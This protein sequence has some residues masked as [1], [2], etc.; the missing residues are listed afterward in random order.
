[1]ENVHDLKINHI[2]SEHRKVGVANAFRNLIFLLESQT[3]I[4][5]SSG[6]TLT[7]LLVKRVLHDQFVKK[8]TKLVV[9]IAM[10]KYINKHAGKYVTNLM[11]VVPAAVKSD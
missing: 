4:A 5:T 6:I 3:I 1:M 9:L 2:V 10:M 7:I 11:P 8:M